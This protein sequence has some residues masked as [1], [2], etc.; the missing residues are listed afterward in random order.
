V[1]L[2]SPIPAIIAAS[3][4]VPVLIAL[5][6][7]KLRR[8]SVRVSST[9]LWTRSVHDVEV[10]VPLRWLRPTWIFLLQFAA[11][12]CLLVALG[13]PALNASDGESGR[14]VLAIDRSASMSARDGIVDGKTATRLDE[15]KARALRLVDDLARGGSGG[16]IGVVDF[17][18]QA[19]VV[20]GLTN[21]MGD[22]RAAIGAIEASDQPGDMAAALRL[23]GS[24]LRPREGA[25]DETSRE[26]PGV[27]RIWSDGVSR[28]TE[29]LS[30]NGAIARYER[31]GGRDDA[32][33]PDNLGIV[34]L[35]AR[36]DF[37][38]PAIVRVFVRVQNA[39][40]RAANASLVLRLDG[41]EVERRAIEVPAW[42]RGKPAT[43]KDDGASEDGQAAVTFA[44]QTRSA[45]VA[46][47][48]IDRADLLACD[49]QASVVLR[50][51]VR[52]R[53]LLV[54]PEG[55]AGSVPD[56]PDARRD[57]GSA[58]AD[59]LLAAALGEM[60]V[61][62]RIEQASAYER[63]VESGTGLAD[64]V[65]FD[66]VRPRE[67]PR[68]ATL[69]F[70][71][72][73]PVPGLDSARR[74]GAGD[75][76]TAVLSWS[77]NHPL[78]RNVGLDSIFVAKTMALPDPSAT[79]EARGTGGVTIREIARGSD[80]PLILVAEDR[81][82]R[83]VVVGFDL[84]QSNWPVQ[85]GFPIFLASAIDYLTLRGQ[86]EAGR[87]FKTHEPAEIEVP[88]SVG[89]SIAGTLVLEGPKRVEMTP[90]QSSAARVDIGVLERAGVYRLAQAPTD[91][92]IEIA[93][94]VC[95]ER[96]SRLDG[97]ERLSIGG[98]TLEGGS[99]EEARRELWTWFVIAGAGLL[100]IEWML[101]AW[102]T[103][104]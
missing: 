91:S 85:V 47:V 100:T 22:V 44:L 18:D 76:A 26:S 2:L 73:L 33:G 48:S 58:I 84:A 68:C 43:G 15:A 61:P 53:V 31:T 80:G 35:A 3:V 17:A 70:G 13:R 101:N 42:V 6:L 59:R 82:V 46:S 77:R 60:G 10:N 94:N 34:A 30:I 23:A 38:D 20:C 11:L 27:V 19:R 62:L 1:T 104:V 99:R 75:R 97:A 36:R 65:V 12:A 86:D 32:S 88:A 66:R 55:E 21:N 4:C 29:P 63:D 92:P 57:D 40:K 9:L 90:P 8:R 93:V 81:G 69:S 56:Q 16:T 54:T 50:A 49:N 79:M 96:T 28:G 39:A 25:I 102:Q 103:R 72:G 14:I 5:Y 74:T 71:A 37:D 83:R 7:L 67:S 87:S 24:M 51:A 64:L 89:A 52:P 98:R 95:D 45:G 41:A 78:L